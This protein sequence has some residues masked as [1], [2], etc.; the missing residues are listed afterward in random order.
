MKNLNIEEVAKIE[1][2]SCEEVCEACEAKYAHAITQ[3]PKNN[4]NITG[5]IIAQIVL[6][7]TNEKNN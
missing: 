3:S 4:T 1:K 6:N 2:C 5:D 7:N